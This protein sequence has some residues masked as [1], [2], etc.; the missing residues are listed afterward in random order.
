MFDTLSGRLGE[1]FDRL[2][3]RGALSEGDVT[4]ALREVRVALLEADVALPVAK[5]FIDEVREQAV[6]CA[7]AQERHARPDGGQGGPRPAR[8]HARRRTR[9]GVARRPVR[10]RCS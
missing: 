2:T 7:R 3:K 4:A 9:A 1:I 6:G 5:S 8:R 10:P